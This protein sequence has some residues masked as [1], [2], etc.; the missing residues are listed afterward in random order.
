MPVADAKAKRMNKKEDSQLEDS[1]VSLTRL[2]GCGPL[3][4]RSN[5]STAVPTSYSPCLHYHRCDL[6]YQRQYL[7][8][9]PVFCN[10]ACTHA[11]I[12]QFVSSP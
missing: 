12:Q 7:I 6:A 1:I 8:V 5:G 4:P 10:V 3:C 9:A 11:G 2:F